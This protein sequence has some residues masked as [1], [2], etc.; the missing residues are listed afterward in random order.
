[1][2][3][4]CLLIFTKRLLKV[5]QNMIVCKNNIH[6]FVMLLCCTMCKQHD[7]KENGYALKLAVN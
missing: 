5:T 3:N 1:M 6:T 2:I 4:I 7:N